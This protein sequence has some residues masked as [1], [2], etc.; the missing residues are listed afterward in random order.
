MSAELDRLEVDLLFEG[1]KE[2]ASTVT[3][4]AAMELWAFA[5]EIANVKTGNLRSSIQAEPSSDLSWVIGTGT[6]YAPFVH[7]GF[8]SFPLNSPVN[9][10]GHWVYIGQH[11]GYKGNP[12]FDDAI[13]DVEGRIDEFIDTAISQLGLE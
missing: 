8:D 13:S 4:I 5:T 9:I 10:D 12:F 7:E 6:E 1:M 3:E 2:I 11:P